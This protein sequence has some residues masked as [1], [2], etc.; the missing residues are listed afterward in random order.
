MTEGLVLLPLTPRRQADSP[1]ETTAVC[2]TLSAPRPL[3]SER[4]RW[5][6]AVNEQQSTHLETASGINNRAACHASES[7]IFAIRRPAEVRDLSVRAQAEH[8]QQRIAA[9]A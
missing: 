3:G 8:Q 7:L 4:V 9:F 1:A 5:R 6:F 2:S